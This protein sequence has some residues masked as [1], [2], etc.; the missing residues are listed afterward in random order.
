VGVREVLQPAGP[1]PVS[2]Y[3]WRRFA[4]VLPLLVFLIVISILAGGSGGQGHNGAS[5]PV[6]ASG[7]S[8]ARTSTPPTTAQTTPPTS[9][10]TTGPPTP[11][12]TT[13]CLPT[14]LTTTVTASSRS[15]PAGQ[16][17]RLAATLM[18]ASG[19]CTAPGALTIVVTSGADRVWGSADCTPTA[20]TSTDL[21]NGGSRTAVVT[22]DRTRS[23]PGCATVNGT[24]TALA[25][26]YRAVAT[27]AGTTSAPFTFTLS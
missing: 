24:R 7:R 25:G 10:P 15:Y 6:S 27:W 8:S 23:D 5:T 22:W 11:T 20:T 1:L 19:A 2:V 12:P 17:V 4:V 13:T 3:W 26:T 16:D 18:T 21:T 9:A 14:A